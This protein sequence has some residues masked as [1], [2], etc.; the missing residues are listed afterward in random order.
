MVQLTLRSVLFA[1]AT[2]CL[3][4][5]GPDP[6]RFEAASV[7]LSPP[8]DQ[9]KPPSFECTGGP[10]T[11][12]P[13]LFA[14][15]YTTLQRLI[16]EAYDLRSFQVPD[17]APRE[18]SF[19]DI[20]ARVPPGTTRAQ[21]Q[22]MKQN[23]LADR[24]KLVF[25]YD[26]KDAQVYDLIVVKSGS[27]M[28]AS[29]P[30]VPTQP[31][32]PATSRERDE[33]GFPLPP[34]DYRGTTM[35]YGAGSGIAHWV[36]RGATMER[37][38]NLLSTVLKRPVTDLTGLQGTYDFTLNF[39][40]AS[41]GLESTP[42]PNAAKQARGGTASADDAPTLFAVLQDQLGLKLETKKGF[43]DIFVVDHAEKMP[44]EN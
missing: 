24:F 3:A 13:G 34:A 12:D 33:Y 1:V 21:F 41:L 8:I 4:A 19:Y 9:T 31:G 23:L 25:H 39:S 22:L 29:P 35:S 44:V 16:I 18:R 2:I 17:T 7:K 10:G 20:S 30:D 40:S 26:K 38:V 32:K 36:A 37:I 15:S 43:I 42:P 28:K 14:C 5:Q 6:P 27:K 11:V